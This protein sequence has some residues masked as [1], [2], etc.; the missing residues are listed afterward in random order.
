MDVQLT[1]KKTYD[2]RYL[3]ASCGV[4]YW[5]DADVNGVEDV[6]G[7]LIPFRDGNSWTPTIDLATGMIRNWP[8]GVTAKIH[9]KVCDD[10][11]Y[12]LLDEF[13]CLVTEIDGYVP[14]MMCPS[15]NGFGDYVIMNIDC[16]GMIEG[17]VVDFIE[18]NDQDQ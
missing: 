15:G 1:I 8:K 6:N 13:D 2:V 11:T 12:C 16:D 14:N 5:E 9:Y 7:D 17:W 18:F 4:R 10:G 3:A